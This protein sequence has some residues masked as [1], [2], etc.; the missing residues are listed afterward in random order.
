MPAENMRGRFWKNEVHKQPCNELG[1]RVIVEV[2]YRF[3]MRW[4]ESI[5]SED[6]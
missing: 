2:K 4:G 3:W 1:W 5:G 6:C